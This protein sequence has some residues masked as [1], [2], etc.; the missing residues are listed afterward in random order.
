MKTRFEEFIRQS[1]DNLEEVEYNPSHWDRIEKELNK[2]KGGSNLKYYIGGAILV[3][4]VAA[5]IMLAPEDSALA[6][7]KQKITEPVKPVSAETTATELVKETKS[8]T[9]ATVEGPK[10]TTLAKMESLK[11]MSV[12][13]AKPVL[14]SPPT[15]SKP[16]VQLAPKT[17]GNGLI[18]TPSVSRLIGCA[19][20]AFYFSVDVNTPVSYEWNF[21][22]GKT[23][24]QPRPAHTYSKAGRYSVMLKV[25]SAIDGKSLVI[26]QGMNLTV[27]AKPEAKL[28]YTVN[29]EAGFARVAEF[30]NNSDNHIASQW[31][32]DGKYYNEET[33]RIKFNHKGN[34]NV[35]LIVKNDVGCYDTSKKVMT[36]DKEYNLMAPTGFTPNNDGL[37]DEFIPLAL[38]DVDVAYT[39]E[40]VDPRTGGVIFKSSKQ[41]WDGVNSNTGRVADEGTYLW[42]VNLI[43]PD[44][45]KEIFKGNITLRTK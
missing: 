44:N 11:P 22:D 14:S 41:G 6:E 20:E 18:A 36:V 30:A 40:V 32:I 19:D 28:A 8:N 15:P 39:L 29:E 1:A 3:G 43:K 23:S 34:Y 9:T 31:I 21:G 27:N 2:K 7:I 12:S 37:N 4:A 26:A 45:S 10:R 24:N 17:S 33:P 42:V 16:E 25:T 38:K 5:A 13:D 35:A